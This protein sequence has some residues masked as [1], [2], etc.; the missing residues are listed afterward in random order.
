MAVDDFTIQLAACVKARRVYKTSCR[1]KLAQR[2]L[3]LYCANLHPV[4]ACNKVSSHRHV[5]AVHVRLV[6]GLPSFAKSTETTDLTQK[7]LMH[8]I[9]SSVTYLQRECI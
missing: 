6:L 3:S 2:L 5:L 8:R 9:M 4:P 1:C 7:L